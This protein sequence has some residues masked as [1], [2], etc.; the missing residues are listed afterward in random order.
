MIT[1]ILLA[2]MIPQIILVMLTGIYLLSGLKRGLQPLHTLAKHIA[3]RSS[4][5]LSPIPETHVFVEVRALADTIND[6]LEQLTQAIA[7]QQRFI[8]NAAHQLRTP[9]AGLKLQAERALREQDMQDMKPALVQIQ[10]CADH[11]SHLT[12]QL[13]VLAQSEP[14]NGGYELQAVDLCE[15]TRRTCIDWVPKALQRNMEISFECRNSI[16]C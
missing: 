6:V 12:S 11:M 7:T 9:L 14:I 4:G 1:D 10:N 13:L 3:A 2:D 5:D 16:V 15:L 8:A